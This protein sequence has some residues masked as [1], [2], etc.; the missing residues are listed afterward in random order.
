M[1]EQMTLILL[2]IVLFIIN[3]VVT[4]ILRESD[5]RKRGIT[6]VKRLTEQYKSEI[7]KHIE[8]FRNEVT[9]IEN[10]IS[11]KDKQL[12]NLIDTVNGEMIKLGSYQEDMA[13]LRQSMDTY[14]DALAGLAKLTTDADSKIGLVETDIKRLED[15]KTM[16]DSFRLDMK[17]ADEHLKAHENTVIQMQKDSEN[18]LEQTIDKFKGEAD[19][20]LNSAKA[21]VLKYYD[22]LEEKLKATQKA[23]E[24]LHHESVTLL[25]GLGDRMSE[26]HVLA[27][28][29]AQ[30][31]KTRNELASNVTSLERQIAE[32]KSFA[33]ELDEISRS[34]SQKLASIKQEMERLETA[35]QFENVITR[36]PAPEPKPEPQPEPETK[37]E[38]EHVAEPVHEAE[39]ELFADALPK[40]EIKDEII[41]ED[42][43]EEEIVF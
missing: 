26:Q 3:L 23:A 27:T 20:V 39:D 22:A 1:L 41:I 33:A 29:I 9:E 42:G 8:S 10:T 31:T 24:D 25:S 6:G 17:D 11:E 21:K 5:S 4:L 30:L 38:P 18:N 32:K 28:Q 7:E 37:A 12:H 19:N 13:N 15:V 2:P 40:E 14:R 35:R 43:E 34:E 16:I 36:T